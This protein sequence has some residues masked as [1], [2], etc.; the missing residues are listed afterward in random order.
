MALSAK[1]GA[2]A[3]FYCFLGN[4][5]AAKPCPAW[6]W[7][8]PAA[9]LL[10]PRPPALRNPSSGSQGKHWL[11]S[12]ERQAASWIIPLP[13]PPPTTVLG[14]GVED[15]GKAGS[16]QTSDCRQTCLASRPPLGSA[17]PRGHRGLGQ[18]AA[19]G[20]PGT[21]LRPPPA[22][23]NPAPESSPHRCA[24]GGEAREK[25]PPPRPR[26]LLPSP[27]GTQALRGR[28][29][30]PRRRFLRSEGSPWPHAEK[31]RPG[32]GVRDRP[33]ALSSTL[34]AGPGASSRKRAGSRAPGDPGRGCTGA[35]APTLPGPGTRAAEPA[36]GAERPGPAGSPRARLPGALA[37]PGPRAPRP[38]CLPSGARAG[39]LL[40]ASAAAARA[41]LGRAKSPAAG[42]WARRGPRAR[43]QRH[44]AE[45]GRRGG[46]ASA[47]PATRA[48]LGLGSSSGAGGGSGRAAAA[49]LV[50]SGRCQRRRRRRRRPGLLLLRRRA[51]PPRGA[52][53][54]LP[55]PPP[56]PAPARPP[57]AHAAR[58]RARFPSAV[59]PSA[60]GPERRPCGAFWGARCLRLPVGADKETEAHNV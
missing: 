17:T 51:P 33:G 55:R 20:S 2:Q 38:R 52:T 35:S 19:E 24:G 48:G 44:G 1:S 23:A 22:P 12:Q 11:L 27:G 8:P 18:A 53:S 15:D 10:A 16:D 37:F 46:A 28:G 3:R 60:S 42:A 26:P 31:Y 56:P 40:Q 49:R 14:H 30:G 4:A 32:P 5:G 57:A 47:R 29:Q 6:A 58:P 13:P 41:P 50:Y 54:A 9:P 39:K 36:P 7:R 59:R 43:R 34:G 25:D 21:Y 45:A